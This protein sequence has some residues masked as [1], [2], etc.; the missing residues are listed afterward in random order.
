MNRQPD[1]NLLNDEHGLVQLDV[2]RIEKTMEPSKKAS[3][4]KLSFSIQRKEATMTGS[5]AELLD[6]KNETYNPMGYY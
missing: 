5:F 3:K 2:Y 4:A 1:L 6:L